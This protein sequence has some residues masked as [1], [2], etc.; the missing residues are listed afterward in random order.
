[1]FSCEGRWDRS[2]AMRLMSFVPAEQLVSVDW[3]ETDWVYPQVAGKNKWFGSL[4]FYD[5]LNGTYCLSS[6]P[7]S[8]H[9]STCEWPYSIFNASY[10][11]EAI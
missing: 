2:H 4:Q 7:V 5:A 6:I 11:V 1:M 8:A 9:C 3:N 10:Q